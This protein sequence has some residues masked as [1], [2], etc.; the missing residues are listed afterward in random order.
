M[1][2]F[3]HNGKSYSIAVNPDL[4]KG[5]DL[6]KILDDKNEVVLR[7][8]IEYDD[9]AD[10]SLAAILLVGETSDNSFDI[11]MTSWDSLIAD[12]IEFA[13]Q[14]LDSDLF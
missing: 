11:Y 2:T 6:L 5:I 9:Y 14:A 12:T 4:G 10:G 3:T 13:K 1:Q 7:S 8:E